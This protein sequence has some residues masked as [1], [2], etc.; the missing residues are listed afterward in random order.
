LF[1]EGVD[2]R[3]VTRL[4]DQAIVPQSRNQAAV[5]HTGPTIDTGYQRSGARG[6][7]VLDALSNM[8][9]A[10]VGSEVHEFGAG[11]QYQYLQNIAGALEGHD[12]GGTRAQ[13]QSLM[14]ELDPLLAQG[15]GGELGGYGELGRMIAQ[16]YFTNMSPGFSKN[17]SGN[18]NFGKMNPYLNF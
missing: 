4:N 12:G 9:E 13:R 16:P 18:Y 17:Q 11:Y 1:A 6:T 2:P 7:D 14:G 10:T 3:E 8:R 5:G 15:S